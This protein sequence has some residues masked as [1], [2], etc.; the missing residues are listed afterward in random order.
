MNFNEMIDRQNTESVKWNWFEKDV[1]PM[2]VADMDFRSPESVVN[3]LHARVEHG[4]FGYG[5]PPVGLSEILIRR[6]HERYG[7]QVNES[8]L[9]YV[10]GIVTG[11]N[12]A[13]RAV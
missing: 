12:L 4:V 11:F 2:W 7:W 3:A 9:S 13:V 10:P 1:L 5:L 8:E 6:M